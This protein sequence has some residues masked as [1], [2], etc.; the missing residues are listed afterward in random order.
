MNDDSN[1]SNS[2]RLYE[3]NAF[4][5][6]GVTSVNE[7]H[8]KAE[9]NENFHIDLLTIFNN[10]DVDESTI[11]MQLF[12]EQGYPVFK[13][14]KGLL[15][16][17]NMPWI[18]KWCKASDMEGKTDVKDDSVFTKLIVKI[19]L[20]NNGQFQQIFTN[21][22][23][24]FTLELQP[25]HAF[26]YIR[27]YIKNEAHITPKHFSIIMAYANN[28][29]NRCSK[30]NIYTIPLEYLQDGS[31]HTQKRLKLF[32]DDETPDTVNFYKAINYINISIQQYW[33]VLGS[34]IP[35]SVD[36]MNILIQWLINNMEYYGNTFNTIITS[37]QLVDNHIP[38]VYIYNNVYM[39]NNRENIIKLIIRYLKQTKAS[40]RVYKSLINNSPIL[41]YLSVLFPQIFASVDV[42]WQ[43][44]MK[45]TTINM[46]N[47]LDH[48]VQT[49]LILKIS[50]LFGVTI[51][52][53][54]N[55]INI[56]GIL[57]IE[58]MY[59]IENVMQIILQN[60][61][62][63]YNQNPNT[64]VPTP[65]VNVQQLQY[66]IQ[67]DDIDINNIDLDN[68]DLDNIEI[69]NNTDFQLQNIPT[70]QIEEVAAEAVEETENQYAINEDY[71]KVYD[72]YTGDDKNIL[73]DVKYMFL[74]YEREIM[75][76]EL[77]KTTKKTTAKIQNALTRLQ[78]FD[79]L[80]SNEKNYA[81]ECQSDKKPIIITTD[82]YIRLRD[83]LSASTGRLTPY[84]EYIRFI[85]ENADQFVNPYYYYI[86]CMI[87]DFHQRK[88]LNPYCVYVQMDKQVRAVYYI[89]FSTAD[90]LFI[91]EKWY[92]QDDNFIG[93]YDESKIVVN[94]GELYYPDPSN[95]GN[96]VKMIMISPNISRFHCINFN[97]SKNYATLPYKFV[98]DI[99]K[100]INLPC[101]F[102]KTQVIPNTASNYNNSLNANNEF[103]RD[104]HFK[105]YMDYINMGNNNSIVYDGINRF[106]QLPTELNILF[107]NKDKY[108]DKYM[109][110]E[111][112]RRIV[113]QGYF[114]SVFD[115]MILNNNSNA[116]LHSGS[117]KPLIVY[118]RPIK[119]LLQ[120]LIENL[121]DDMFMTM[122]NGLIRYEFGTKD[123]F[124]QY[125]IDNYF[126]LNEDILWEWISTV[127][128]V[129]IFIISKVNRTVVK[130][131]ATSEYYTLEFPQ[132]YDLAKLY[133]HPWSMFI[134][135]YTNARSDVIYDLIDKVQM[136][137]HTKEI[138]T[139]NFNPYIETKS[140]FVQMLI[141][142]L[143]DTN[144]Q[145]YFDQSVKSYTPTAKE[146]VDYVNLQVIGQTR[147]FNLVYTDNVI[148][149]MSN[150]S[151]VIMPVY[152]TTLLP[153]TIPVMKINFPMYK[154]KTIL[155]I[156]N[157]INQHK[158][159][160]DHTYWYYP[161][162]VITDSTE[163]VSMGFIFDK[164]IQMY[165]HPI[166]YNNKITPTS[167]GD[168]TLQ[169]VKQFF[170]PNNSFVAIENRT[171]ADN[172]R[173]RY[174]TQKNIIK[175]IIF[176]VEYMLSTK[177][178]PA[179][180][181]YLK[182]IFSMDTNANW[183][184]IGNALYDFVEKYIDMFTTMDPNKRYQ[185]N[186][187]HVNISNII[188]N[189]D[190]NLITTYKGSQ[191][192]N[193]YTAQSEGECSVIPICKWSDNQCK[194][195]LNTEELKKNVINYIVNELMSVF[196]PARY[197]IMYGSSFSTEP[198]VIQNY[199][200][201]Y[202]YVINASNAVSAI[203]TLENLI[204]GDEISSLAE[205]MKI[206]YT[207]THNFNDIQKQQVTTLLRSL[208]NQI[209][210]EVLYQVSLPCG[211]NNYI[212][213]MLD[214][215]NDFWFTTMITL[216]QRSN[217]VTIPDL[218]KALA[219]I[220]YKNKFIRAPYKA[221]YVYNGFMLANY[222]RKL[223]R[224]YGVEL[225]NNDQQYDSLFDKVI[226][227]FRSN[228]NNR[229]G[230]QYFP[231]YLDIEALM[232][233]PWNDYN[234]AIIKPVKTFETFT[235]E[236]VTLGDGEY[237][238]LDYNSSHPSQ[239]YNTM[240]CDNLPENTSEENISDMAFY[241]ERKNYMVYMEMT[242]GNN[243]TIFKQLVKYDPSIQLQSFEFTPE[244]I[245]CLK[246]HE[247]KMYNYNITNWLLYGNIPLQI[248]S[249][250]SKDDDGKEYLSLACGVNL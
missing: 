19:R 227:I 32:A 52:I 53:G 216:A 153:D 39:T 51:N 185:I 46:V 90:D 28:F 182:N 225:N 201:E 126:M 238:L 152:P 103:F 175:S 71:F 82:E 177:I 230:I 121:T 176:S 231:T 236:A 205:N 166:K 168:P 161:R 99:V 122:K 200:P 237:E 178:S 16:E 112:C 22:I 164:N 250:G 116:V 249:M 141:K 63:E 111:W 147:T 151:T 123:A 222:Y 191:I 167:I 240:I 31:V 40:Y 138:N 150:G 21:D 14:W 9:L 172:N 209:N 130:K 145:I 159:Q 34:S 239:Q 148:F 85:Y 107:N 184:T 33:R 187:S 54:L 100:R 43:E 146:F 195:C 64:A 224:F 2:I 18:S 24:Y 17:D 181:E 69:D 180:R 1:G 26:A 199:H 13:I 117:N 245:A 190:D 57:N 92:P 115:F 65:H 75:A 105:S 113:F 183:D 120:F 124:V 208:T 135:K 62:Q 142:T 61:L 49:E 25:E 171:T 93:R 173:D 163:F 76:N 67:Q 7:V 186:T 133:S 89:P 102:S 30:L 66:D 155:A 96:L 218:R 228:P 217:I 78:R 207:L 241:K 211:N 128:N 210:P 23:A 144:N 219:D 41:K 55:N 192:Q 56:L 81:T 11:F 188:T 58:Q 220:L 149:K 70:E 60:F 235:K 50:N 88:I 204:R 127:F 59:M 244:D 160:S 143:Q 4:N 106:V 246:A 91:T 139:L 206:I 8:L 10:I 203:N 6:D 233:A 42:M 5:Q 101:C 154:R 94:N 27:F 162:A 98:P 20:A 79:G 72:K 202:Q 193:C 118:Y 110:D 48:E 95:N 36:T 73:Q 104:Y 243:V 229:E 129:N 189:K 12:S 83:Q 232:L 84:G 212:V 137:N 226:D 170:K 131:V 158:R 140:A 196:N 97:S 38:L 37:K 74:D 215:S 247:Q 165:F 242:F 157:D 221:N 174:V 45:K 77:G 213:N 3:N 198:K 44:F 29:I 132:G 86:C 68:L 134:Y 179:W 119:Q 15:H 248:W 87:F 80:I 169:L 136:Q 194:V 214:H 125:C 114:V 35:R 47:Y 156:I 197:K 108:A 223:M 109:K 234:I